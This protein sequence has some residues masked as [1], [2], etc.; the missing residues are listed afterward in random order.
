MMTSDQEQVNDGDDNDDDL[1]PAV[2][3]GLTQWPSYSRTPASSS[4]SPLSS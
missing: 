3:R 2:G 1:S 4:S